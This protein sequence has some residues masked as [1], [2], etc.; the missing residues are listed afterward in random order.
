MPER[1]LVVAKTG[2]KNDAGQK[3]VCIAVFS[4]RHKRL[5]RPVA[6]TGNAAPFWD[7]SAVEAISVGQVVLLTG[8]CQEV[9]SDFPHRTNDVPCEQISPA[10]GIQKVTMQLMHEGLE[11][12]ASTT[13]ESIWPR[14]VRDSSSAKLV[15]AG[16]EVSS[17]GVLRGSIGHLS[18]C[19][20]KL[21]ANIDAG[22]ELL[23]GIPV[24]SLSMRDKSARSAIINRQGLLLLGLARPNAVLGLTRSEAACQILL[25]GWVPHPEQSESSCEEEGLLAS[26][27]SFR[28]GP[29]PRCSVDELASCFGRFLSSGSH[30]V[31]DPIDMAA[32]GTLI[33]LLATEDDS[34]AGIWFEAN[35]HSA[36][37]YSLLPDIA[38]L[39]H[40][41][42]VKWSE[43]IPASDSDTSSGASRSDS[44]TYRIIATGHVPR[45]KTVTASAQRQRLSSSMQAWR[46]S[47][48][49]HLVQAAYQPASPSHISHC[50][51]CI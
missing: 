38:L 22:G 7:P 17:L 37:V 28:A 15:C 10:D 42:T 31:S 19:K 26:V 11:D 27:F 6:S 4:E 16:A 2:A 51:H 40:D 43:I 34:D 39:Q 3:G 32:I 24:T 45:G 13:L 30:N 21:F 41:E 14:N 47:E 23:K 12:M 44:C 5:I 35:E 36:V 29:S 49:S 48:M 20:S 46:S 50:S 33:L 9:T 8:V 18:L 1:G 25:I